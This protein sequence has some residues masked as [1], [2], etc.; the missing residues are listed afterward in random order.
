MD[1]HYCLQVL[2]NTLSRVNAMHKQ[3]SA[4]SLPKPLPQ[5]KDA[6]QLTYRMTLKDVPKLALK[7]DDNGMFKLLIQELLDIKINTQNE[8]GD[9]TKR[10]KML[11]IAEPKSSLLP[12]ENNRIKIKFND[13][14]SDSNQMGSQHN[15][16]GRE[17][18]VSPVKLNFS[19]SSATSMR[20][21]VDESKSQLDSVKAMEKI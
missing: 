16:L 18:P 5:I 9:F 21:Y 15:T 10:F 20:S 6:K 19:H 11:A 2:E 7:F 4:V 17:T 8:E 3:H 14:K 13:E 12:F 1:W